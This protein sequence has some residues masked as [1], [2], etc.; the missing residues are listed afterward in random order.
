MMHSCWI[1]SPSLSRNIDHFMMILRLG[2]SLDDCDA[3]LFLAIHGSLWSKR[4][5]FHQ[6]QS[7]IQ[8]ESYARFQTVTDLRSVSSVV[9]GCISPV[10]INTLPGYGATG[11]RL[12]V[13]LSA[14]IHPTSAL[15]VDIHTA[16]QPTVNLIPIHLPIV[17]EQ[18]RLIM[19]APR[20]VF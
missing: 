19:F 18:C 8:P 1:H 20:L 13:P 12:S 9:Y 16:F 5:S 15:H 6:H 2:S 11:Y 17:C 7:W 4:M 3:T 10:R 14:F